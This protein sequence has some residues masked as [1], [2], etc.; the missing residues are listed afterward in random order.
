M[1]VLKKKCF[2]FE[3]LYSF[4]GKNKMPNHDIISQEQKRKAI[5]FLVAV[6]QENL[7]NI[8]SYC[9]AYT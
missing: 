1:I 5:N 4:Q 6:A 7:E 2:N 9:D 3:T 8:Q